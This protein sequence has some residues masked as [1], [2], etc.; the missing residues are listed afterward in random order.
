MKKAFTSSSPS[1]ETCWQVNPVTLIHIIQYMR[2]D[3]LIPGIVAVCPWG[4]E[5]GKLMYSSMFGHVPTCVY[6]S[7]RQNES[8]IPEQQRK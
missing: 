6:M 2:C 5:S 7:H 1:T 3:Y 4:V 8:F